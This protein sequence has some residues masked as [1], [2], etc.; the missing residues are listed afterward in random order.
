MD[1][2][3][4][5]CLQVCDSPEEHKGKPVFTLEESDL[6]PVSAETGPPE[7]L[8][9]TTEALSTTTSSAETVPTAAG[10]TQVFLQLHTERSLVTWSWYQTF[11]R[12]HELL[13]TSGSE[14]KTRPSLVGSYGLMGQ[15]TTGGPIAAETTTGVPSTVTTTTTTQTPTAPSTAEATSSS[16]SPEFLGS[17]GSPGSVGV[18]CVW[19]FAGSLLLCLAA[20]ACVLVTLVRLVVWYRTVY[21]PVSTARLRGTKGREEVE[22]LQKSRTEE[23][24]ATALYRSV[25]FISREEEEAAG[26]EEGGRGVYRKTLYR[27]VR[28][29]EEIEGWRDVM[30]EC[31][32]SGRRGVRGHQ[33]L[34]GGEGGGGKK[35]YSVIL[36]EEREEQGGGREEL[37]WVVG[38]WEVK[39]GPGVGEEV[40][41]SSWGEW[42][43]HYLPSMPWGVTT[44]PEEEAVQ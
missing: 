34:I 36:R 41:R 44:P 15:P 25:L 35:R 5:V 42:L 4:F 28:K 1:L 22:L 37:D 40:P 12:Y 11:T 39:R 43:A 6:C 2:S 20:A 9:G 27:V 18:F 31:R 10:P 7:E 21:R 24:G 16:S 38:G 23:R 30:E 3:G 17:A 32:V 29:E 14:I 19:L 8:Q 26:E 33:D 13:H